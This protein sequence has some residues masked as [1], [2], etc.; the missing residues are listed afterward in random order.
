MD[1]TTYVTAEGDRIVLEL[2]SARY[3]LRQLTNVREG[4]KVA[5]L[6][7][8]LVPCKD[9][10]YDPS[11]EIRT[12]ASTVS[13][14]LDLA[15]LERLFRGRALTHVVA[16]GDR[17]EHE[18]RLHKGNMDRAWNAC[19]VDLVQCSRVHC[20]Y[21]M[22]NNFVSVLGKIEDE[23]ARTAMGHV[24]RFFALQNIAEDFGSFM[25][26]RPQQQ[27]CKEALR[28]LMPLLR[29]D[30]IGLTDAFEFP[31]NVLNSALGKSFN[32]WPT[33]TC[34]NKLFSNRTL[35]RQGLREPV[36]GCQAQPP[37]PPG[38]LLRIQGVPP[39]HP[40]PGLHRR[41]EEAPAF[42]RCRGQIVTLLPAIP[43]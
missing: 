13:A 20:Y 4:R 18:L 17:L 16:A 38:P 8:Y 36:R 28:G 22:L 19:A 41:E 27:V 15:L 6:C 23:A 30:V 1:Y 21:V 12:S 31:D 43:I 10:G 25:L 32:P 42:W 7:E 3:L 26:T 14:W 33:Y 5:G 39:A 29:H 35:R 11:A 37:Q 40:R 24:C 34:T 9:K 2:Q